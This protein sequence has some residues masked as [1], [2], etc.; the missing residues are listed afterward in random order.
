MGF[1][2]PV[3][4]KYALGVG[5]HHGSN[6]AR[7]FVVELLRDGKL[8]ALFLEGDSDSQGRLEEVK[9]D[10]DDDKFATNCCA[11]LAGANLPDYNSGIFLG[12]LAAAAIRLN[13]P[14]YLACGL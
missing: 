13:V 6:D 10:K 14:V 11:A 7:R 1:A 2:R 5:E 9:K 4:R 12:Y 3:L 8:R